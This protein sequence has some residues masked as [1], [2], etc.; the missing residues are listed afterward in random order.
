MGRHAAP[1]P[2][3]APDSP[4]AHPG[5]TAPERSGL[6]PPGHSEGRAVLGPWG[7]LIAGLATGAAAGGVLWWAGQPPSTAALVA[8]GAVVV[9]LVA[10]WV[11]RTVT[12]RHPVQ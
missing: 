1:G 11:A 10:A 6:A 12:G 5:P 2:P 3:D 7:S 4:A 9:V 8:G